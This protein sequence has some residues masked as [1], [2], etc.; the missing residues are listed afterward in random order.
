MLKQPFSFYSFNVSINEEQAR[1]IMDQTYPLT[2]QAHIQGLIDEKDAV[3]SELTS[4]R[5][6]I[7]TFKATEE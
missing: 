7:K 4:I 1:E 2:L 6:M 3:T 5:K